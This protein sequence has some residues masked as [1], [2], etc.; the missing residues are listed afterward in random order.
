MKTGAGACRNYRRGGEKNQWRRMVANEVLR[1]TAGREKKEFV[2]YLTGPQ[3]TDRDVFIEK[4]VPRRNL[5]AVDHVNE[6]VS[7]MRDRQNY[8]ITDEIM[9]VLW[10]WP[11]DRPVCAVLLDFCCGFERWIEELFDAFSNP[12][13]RAAVVAVNLQRGRDKSSNDVRSLLTDHAALDDK[14]RAKA[15]LRSSILRWYYKIERGQGRTPSIFEGV[16][17]LP[18][19]EAKLQARYESYRSGGLVFDSAICTFA[20]VFLPVEAARWKDSWKDFPNDARRKPSTQR[21][22]AAQFALRTMQRSGTFPVQ[23]ASRR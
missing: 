19:V 12:A 21:R 3:D 6:N 16:K 18:S 23:S 11:A 15:L 13:L 17:R 4:G 9:N 2:I 1:R 14:H 20:W 22:L 5:F 10:S 7:R 8:G